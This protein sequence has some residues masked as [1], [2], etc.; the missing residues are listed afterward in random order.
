MQRLLLSGKKARNDQVHTYTTG[1][2][3]FARTKD[4]YNEVYGMLKLLPAFPD[5]DN[6]ASTSAAGAC[7]KQ[8]SSSPSPFMNEDHYSPVI[9]HPSFGY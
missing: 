9:D 7:D 4:I 8:P 6:V 3:S 5:L 1:A 2:V